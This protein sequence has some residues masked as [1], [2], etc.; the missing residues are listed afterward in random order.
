MNIS[1]SNCSVNHTSRWNSSPLGSTIVSSTVGLFVAGETILG[2]SK[3][4]A[5]VRLAR[6]V[7]ELISGFESTDIS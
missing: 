6:V 4:G 5:V 3:A 7:D 2:S 1:L